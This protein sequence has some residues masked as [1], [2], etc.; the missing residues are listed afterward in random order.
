MPTLQRPDFAT[1]AARWRACTRTVRRW[2]KAGVDLEDLESV[3][4]HLLT[5]KRPSIQAAAVVIHEL[6]QPLKSHAH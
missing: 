5:Q 1:A 2:H 4:R 6:S 3:A